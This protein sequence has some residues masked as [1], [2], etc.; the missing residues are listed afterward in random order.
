MSFEDADQAPGGLSLLRKLW[1][2]IAYCPRGK[3]RRSRRL[4]RKVDQQH[5][6]RCH[7]C[8]IPMVR[9]A[10]RNWVVDERRK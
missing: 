5:L 6:S 8:G 7:Y 1:G 4:V 2:R 3:H 9:I 10:K